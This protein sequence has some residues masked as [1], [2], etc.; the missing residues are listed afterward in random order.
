[1][2]GRS[3]HT[4]L[5]AEKTKPHPFHCLYSSLRC[6]HR[7]RGSFGRLV[8]ICTKSGADVLLKWV[9]LYYI[10]SV[11]HSFP[12]AFFPIVCL[13]P[14]SHL[15]IEVSRHLYYTTLQLINNTLGR[16]KSNPHLSS[17]CLLLRSCVFP[18]PFFF[19]QPN[20]KRK[21]PKT[22]KCLET[23]Y[24]LHP[25]DYT[26]ISA[27]LAWNN[28]LANSRCRLACVCMCVEFWLSK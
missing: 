18:L 13:F 22:A 20:H 6:V 4:N 3:S 24:G 15:A 2:C 9:G 7:G 14:L 8:A 25:G 10:T 19:L 17:F 26:V 21:W 28:S 12:I 27:K 11:F 16:K 1:M 5:F 23:Q